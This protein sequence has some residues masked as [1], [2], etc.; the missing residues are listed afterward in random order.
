MPDEPASIDIFRTVSRGGQ[1]ARPTQR[2]ST[3]ES[4][5]LFFYADGLRDKSR[6]PRRWQ[7]NLPTGH[8]CLR[9]ASSLSPPEPDER[10]GERD[11]EHDSEIAHV[12]E[13]HGAVADAGNGTDALHRGGEPLRSDQELDGGGRDG[14]QQA[15]HQSDE[16]GLQIAHGLHRLAEP[17]YRGQKIVESGPAWCLIRSSVDQVRP[18]RSEYYRRRVCAVRD[19]CL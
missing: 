7:R 16:R 4:H 5:L 3:N 2:S 14:Q 11:D 9:D 15:A 12:A 8:G 18:V 6:Y 13:L 19:R 1:R 10:A 17:V